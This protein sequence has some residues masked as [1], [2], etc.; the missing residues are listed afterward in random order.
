MSPLF[1]DAARCRPL[2]LVTCSSPTRGRRPRDGDASTD[3]GIHQ[4]QPPRNTV[5]SAGFSHGRG[6]FV[7]D[8]TFIRGRSRGSGCPIGLRRIGAILRVIG[9]SE[10]PS[11]KT[12]PYGC[13][14]GS[15]KGRK[16]VPTSTARPSASRDGNVPI[17]L[18]KSP[19][20]DRKLARTF[21]RACSATRSARS[22]TL[23]PT[24]LVGRSSSV[25]SPASISVTVI[26]SA[27]HTGAS[28][29]PKTPGAAECRPGCTQTRTRLPAAALFATIAP[30]TPRT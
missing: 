30:G 5:S 7:G 3:A 22:V 11:S 1:A 28:Q 4:S 13:R 29:A 6:A 25:C 24:G 18:S 23:R 19:V 9:C 14:S 17:D 8:V 26:P 10:S 2:F 15:I 20:R 16:F 12:S 27:A 21:S